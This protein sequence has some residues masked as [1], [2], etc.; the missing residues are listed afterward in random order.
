M[1]GPVRP[2]VAVLVLDFSLLADFC[3][4]AIMSGPVRLTVEEPC[5]AC[6]EGSLPADGCKA[7]LESGPVRCE[8]SREFSLG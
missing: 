4:E 1:S 7:A 2:C 5:E 6:S 8:M 3:C